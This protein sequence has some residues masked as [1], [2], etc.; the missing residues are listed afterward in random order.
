MLDLTESLDALVELDRHPVGLVNHKGNPMAKV[1]EVPLDLADGVADE[2]AAVYSLVAAKLDC[3][4]LGRALQRLSDLERQVI[5]LRYGI[6]CAPMTMRQVA[7]VLGNSAAT[8]CRLEE[9]AIEALFYHW[10]HDG[11]AA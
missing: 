2:R 8:V 1:K 4:R 5:A 7:V 9:R 6:G 3:E 10:H 11:L